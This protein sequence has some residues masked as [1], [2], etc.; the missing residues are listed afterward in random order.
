[1]F[2]SR[3]SHHDIDGIVRSLRE[4]VDDVAGDRQTVYGD[5][6]HALADAVWVHDADVVV[7]APERAV[8]L[9]ALHVRRDAGVDAQSVEFRLY[10]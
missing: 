1:M 4:Y 5:G 7:G 2:C 6:L 8:Q 3:L 10:A 9:I